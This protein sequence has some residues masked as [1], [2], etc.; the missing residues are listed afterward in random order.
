LFRKPK[1]VQFDHNSALDRPFQILPNG[2]ATVLKHGKKK[3]ITGSPEKKKRF[4]KE[5]RE[6]HRSERR[7]ELI[8]K[9]G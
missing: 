9:A 8:K 6:G 1:S 5:R 3:D 2:Y 4:K 7:G